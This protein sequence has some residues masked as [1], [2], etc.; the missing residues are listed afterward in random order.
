MEQWLPVEG[1]ED[2]EVSDQG[3]VK[4]VVYGRGTNA[5]DG[6]L[7]Q[8]ISRKGYPRV[9][10]SRNSKKYTKATHILVAKAFIPN[11]NSLPQVNHKNGNKLD[12]KVSNLEWATQIS[13]MQ[14]SAKLGL[15]GA[16]I[17]RSQTA[18]KWCASYN[19]EPYKKVHLGTFNSEKEALIARA[20]AIASIGYVV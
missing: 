13:N 3:R 19:P 16:G 7:K 18:G 14:H 2:Y 10:F 15:H 9:Y 6:L 12:A 20:T 1:F 4:R 17:R 8:G 5:V 11:P